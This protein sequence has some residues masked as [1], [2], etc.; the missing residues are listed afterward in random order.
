LNKSELRDGL[1]AMLDLLGAEKKNYD[2]NKL[3]EECIKILDTNGDGKISKDE[4]VNGLA[5][6]YSLRVLMSPFN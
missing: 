3:V 6:N 1:A 4:F 5:K 2:I